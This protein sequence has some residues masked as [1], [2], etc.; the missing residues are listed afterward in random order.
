MHTN[1]VEVTVAFPLHFISGHLNITVSYPLPLSTDT[2][3]KCS[4]I[5]FWSFAF[6]KCWCGA[7]LK[8]ISG[9]TA[10]VTFSTI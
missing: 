5:L 7:L 2:V 8:L 3:Y 10:G 9:A 1:K 6:F 4:S